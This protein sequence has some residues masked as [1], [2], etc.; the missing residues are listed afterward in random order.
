[1]DIRDNPALLD[2]LAAS[3][4]LGTL[5]GGAR[6]RFE[7]LAR[8]SAVVR[9]SALLWQE[10]LVSLT[11]LQPA[12]APS[13]NVWKRIENLLAAQQAPAASVP[14]ALLP[15]PLRRALGW[16]RA[17]ALAGGLAAVAA[18]AV[19]V[20]LNHEVARQQGLLAQAQGERKVLA[21]RLDATPSIQYVSILQDEKSGAAMLVTVD[22]HRNTLTLKR[23]DGRYQ[24]PGDKSLE[25]WALPADAGGKPQSLGVLASGRIM[26]LPGSVGAAA[27]APALAITLEPKGGAPAASPTG[28]V[29]FKGPM[30]P[31]SL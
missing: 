17:A 27:Q 9:S 24:E 11:E 10:R 6:R 16:W 14:V 13:P 22:R 19:S 25:L 8:E 18:V 29:L 30:V 26:R 2:Q 1:M 7:T 31:T 28:P 3:H 20:R 21:A 23:V 5:R 12:Q 4:A 15:S